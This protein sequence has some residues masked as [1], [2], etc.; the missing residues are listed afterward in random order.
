MKDVELFEVTSPSGEKYVL[1]KVENGIIY[2][3]WRGSN[4]EIG[5]WSYRVKL[6]ESVLSGSAI[7]VEVFGESAEGKS[8]QVSML[9]N[10]FLFVT[11]E[12]DKKS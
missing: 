9:K 3:H 6:Y 5:I 7:S 11:D 10:F 1:P 8:I 12:Q 2:F 4:N